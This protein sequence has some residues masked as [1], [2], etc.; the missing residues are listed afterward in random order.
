[1]QVFT[2]E[3]IKNN[4]KFSATFGIGQGGGSMIGA[5]L[6]YMPAINLG[7]QAGIGYSFAGE[8]VT[9]RAKSAVTLFSV[10]PG[11]AIGGALN[12]HMRQSIK[13]D[14][15]S[16]LYWY[17]FGDIDESFFLQSIVGATYVWRS[18]K[19]FTAQVGLGT[20]VSPVGDEEPV[21]LLLFSIG[22]YFPF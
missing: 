15:I 5:D 19:W 14:F 3:A 12:C 4:E 13:S 22:A 8:G 10:G 2:Q 6:E 9:M 11:L 17:R 18:P 1:M 21:V 20:P 16:L 7:I